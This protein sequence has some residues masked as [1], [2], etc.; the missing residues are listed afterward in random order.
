MIIPDL[1]VVTM[2]HRNWPEWVLME[3]VAGTVVYQ[4]HV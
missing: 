4:H 2:V 3:A 1:Q